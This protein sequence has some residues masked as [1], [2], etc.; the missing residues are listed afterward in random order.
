MGW[1]SKTKPTRANIRKRIT[2]ALEAIEGA[3]TLAE[4][5]GGMSRT[6]SALNNAGAWVL[7]ADAKTRARKR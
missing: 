3:K 6:I 2:A 1:S 7:D 4:N 5:H